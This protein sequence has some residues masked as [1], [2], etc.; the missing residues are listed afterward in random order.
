MASK[1]G[2]IVANDASEAGI[3]NVERP[4]GG[5]FESIL[6]EKRKQ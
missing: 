2:D 6:Y 1:I 4:E 5:R 3:L